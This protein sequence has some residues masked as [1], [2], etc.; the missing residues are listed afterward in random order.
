MGF[1]DW[2]LPVV[3]GSYKTHKIHSEHSN[4]RQT[5]CSSNK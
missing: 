2:Q 3:I 4:T 1:V 5:K